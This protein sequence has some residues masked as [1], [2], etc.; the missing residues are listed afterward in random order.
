[1]IDRDLPI[2]IAGHRLQRKNDRCLLRFRFEPF[3]KTNCEFENRS[4]NFASR[5]Y[6]ALNKNKNL[7]T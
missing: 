7:S 3:R 2:S 5:K 1:M 4:K 6:L